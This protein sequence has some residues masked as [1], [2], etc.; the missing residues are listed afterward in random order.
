MAV[1]GHEAV[2]FAVNFRIRPEFAT[3]IDELARRRGINR[4]ALM[5]ELVTEECIRLA[6]QETG[7]ARDAG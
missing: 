5:R 7:L 3:I 1:G 4:S 2:D 6:E